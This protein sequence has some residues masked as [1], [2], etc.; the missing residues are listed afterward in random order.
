MS[1]RHEE[2][3]L[4]RSN[5]SLYDAICE[6]NYMFHREIFELVGKEIQSRQRAGGLAILDLG[7]GNARHLAPCLRSAPPRRYVGV[8]LSAAALEEAETHLA[9]LAGV[10]LH[11]GD[12]LF[13][14][15]KLPET[16]DVV[17]SSFAVHHLQ[18]AEKQALFEAC[19]RRLAPGGALLLVDVIREEG[20]SPAQGMAE[21]L[22]MMRSAWTKVPAADIEAACAHVAAYDFPETLSELSRLVRAVGLQEG[23]PLGRFGRHAVVLFPA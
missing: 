8:D 19:A 10:S 7:C 9:G 22:Q 18:T 4:F 1:S 17:F 20:Q 15:Q 2:T 3:A 16:F 13:A 23:R 11:H 12:M 6:H 21:Y 14:A 5:W